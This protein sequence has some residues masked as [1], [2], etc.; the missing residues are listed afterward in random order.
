MARL[1]GDPKA[2]K[3][4]KDNEKNLGNFFGWLRSTCCCIM[5]CGCCGCH[6]NFKRKSDRAM[7]KK[8]RDE[9]QAKQNPTVPVT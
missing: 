2:I 8:L 9:Y 6:Y 1:R 3:E 7:V 4:D 5:C